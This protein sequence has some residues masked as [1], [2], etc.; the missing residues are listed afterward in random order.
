MYA[1][2]V[3]FNYNINISISAPYKFNIYT[4]QMIKHKIFK[5]YL[6]VKMD[7]GKR[8]NCRNWV[9]VSFFAVLKIK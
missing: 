2:G 5:V 4:I 7:L 3:C 6:A 1:V 8:Q 9:I